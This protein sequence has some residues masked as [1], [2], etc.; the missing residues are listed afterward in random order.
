LFCVCVSNCG[1][2]YNI[3][4]LPFLYPGIG[5]PVENVF[6]K[7]KLLMRC[8]V[9]ESAR[10]AVEIAH[11]HFPGV[12][13]KWGDNGLDEIIQDDSIP[14]VAVVLAGQTQVSYVL[15]LSSIYPQIGSLVC[16]SYN[17]FAHNR[18]FYLG[19]YICC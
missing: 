17:I 3:L 15:L 11:K 5:F 19:F 12:L 16:F 4:L 18:F 14:G 6:G 8:S 9:Q 10:G 2:Y 1:S 13:C 7:R